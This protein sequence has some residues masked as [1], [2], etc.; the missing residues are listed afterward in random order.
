MMEAYQIIRDAILNKRQI[1]ATY[2]GH[3]REL[4]PHVLGTKNGRAQAL[5]YQFGG[6]SSSGLAPMGSGQNWRCMFIDELEDVHA[7]DG[8]WYS[9]P[10][11]SR[12]QTCV[13]VIDVEVSF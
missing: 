3:V 7:R 1:I 4:C 8:E 6:E 5:F 13:G 11:H 12:P 9:A 10:N 2:R